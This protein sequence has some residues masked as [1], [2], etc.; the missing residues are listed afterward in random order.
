[1]KTNFLSKAYGGVMEARH[2]LYGLGLPRQWK[3]MTSTLLLLFTFAIGNVWAADPVENVGTYSTQVISADGTTS[4]WTFITPGSQVTIPTSP[5]E[6]EDNDIIFHPGGGSKMKFSSRN[7]LSW[8]GNSDGYIY[9]PAGAAGSISMTVK[10]ASDSRWLQ[11]Y[12][13]GVDQGS[14]KRLWSKEANPATAARGPRTFTFTSS[15]LTTKGEKTYLHL[16]D[17]NTEM[18]IATISITLTTGTYITPDCEDP[19]TALS[20]SSNAAATVYVG[21]E[22]TFSTSGGNGGTITIA[23]AASET[24]SD[25]KWTAT[26]GEH[27]FTASQAKN[28][29]YCGQADELVLTVNPKTPVT[30]VTI[31]G[32]TAGYLNDE[33]TFTA[34]AEYATSYRWTIDGVAQLSTTATMSFTPTTAKACSIICEAR[35]DFNDPGD[36]IA[37]TAHTY[38]ASK[39]C[40]ELIKIVQNGQSDGNV[41]GILTG[42]KDVKLSSGTSEYDEKTGRKIGSND[43]WLGVKELSKPL[44]AGDVATI[45]VTTV[46]AKL[47]L[48]ADKGTTLIGEME[49]GVVQGENEIVLNSSATGATAIYLYRT[50]T[51]GSDMNP[52]VHSLS[53]S[54]SCTESDD[55]S[56]SDVTINGESITPVGKVYSYEVA[57][58]SALTEVA[59][60]YAI[61]P[62]ATASPTSGFNVAVP[63]AGDPAN[64]QTITVTA[65][66]GTH[67]DTYTVSVTKAATASDVVTLDALAVTGYTLAPTFDAATLAYTITKAYGTAD[68]TADKVT[69]T[70]SEE[71]QTVDVVYDGTNHKFVVTVTA[72]DNTTTQDYEITINEAEAPK[73]LSRVL[74]SNGFDAFIDNTNHTVKAYYLAGATAPTATTITAGAGTA[75]E[76]S[77]GKIR[78][79]GADDSYVDYIVTLAEVTPNTTTVA[80]EAAAGE[81]AGDE[82]WVKNGLLVYGNAAGY[83]TGDKWYVN[84]RLKKGTDSEDDQRVIAGW[85]RSYFF[86]GNASKFIMTVGGNRNLDYTIDGGTP[87]ENV[88]VETLEIALTKGNHMIEIVS[89]QQSGDCRLSAPKLVELPASHTVTYMP[90]DGTGSWVVDDDAIEVAD[91]PNTFT[92]P[93]GKIFNGWKDG[94]NN[95]VEVGAAVTTD[96]ALTAQWINHYA[97]TFYMN[98][99]GDAIDPQ[100][101]KEGAK[102]TKPADPVVMGFDFGGWFTD[103]ACT[104]GNEF[105]F[106]TPITAATPLFAKWTEFEGCALLYPALS[107]DALHVGDNVAV[108]TGSAGGSIAVVGM[109]EEGSIAYD[110]NGLSLNGGGADV[111]SVTLNNDIAVGTKISVTLVA[112]NTGSRGLNLLNATGGKVKGGTKLGWDDATLGE[113]G[114]FSYTVEASDGLEGTNIFRLQRNNSVYLQCVKVESCGAAI[115]YHNLTSEVN[116]AGKGTVTLGASSVR[117]GYTT[118]A[119]YSEIDPLYEFVNWTVSGAGASIADASANPATITMGTE[120]AVVTLNLRLIPVKF[121]V[122]YYDGATL[123]GSEQVAVNENPTASEIVTAKRHYTFLGWSDT[124]GGDVVALNT[125]TRAEAGTVKLYAKYEAVVCPTS[126]TIFSMESDEAKKP[127]STVTI[128]KDA[129]IDLAEYA[130]ISGGNAMIINGET[131]GKDAIST[132]GE[133]LLKATKEVMKIELNCVLQEGDIIRILDNSA[134]LVISTSNA[135][136]GTYQAFADKNTHEFAVTAAWAGVDDIYVL[137]DGSSLKFTKVYVIRPA[138]YTVSFNLMGHGSAIADI[139]NVL[140]GSKITA[141]TAPT[142][143]D[144]SFAG[145]YKENTLA[146]EWKFDV[147]VVEANTTLYAKWLD[148]SDATLKSLK[149]GSTDIALEDGVF[150][151]NIALA[152]AT[153]AVPALTAVTNNPAATAV[154]TD[155]DAFDGDGKATSTVEVTP[156]KEGAAH[157]TYTVNFSKLAALPQV[158]VTGFTTWNFSAGGSTTL[159]NQSDVVLA[160]LPGINNDENF[161]SQALLGSFNKMEGTYFQGSKLSFTTEVPGKLTITFRGTNGNTRHL[162]ACVG[163]GETVVADW[164]Y[165][166]SSTSQTKTI[167]VP[168]GKVTLKAFEGETPNN[169]RIYNMTFNATPD[170]PRDV[171]E[172]RYGTICLPNSG[173]MTGADIFE[174]A[175]FEPS[176]SKIFFDQIVNGVMEAGMPYIFLPKAGATQLGV[177]YTD[178]ANAS[179]GHHN[180]LYGSYAQTELGTDGS[181]YIL[182]NNQYCQVINERVYVGANR[183]YIKLNEVSGTAVAPAPGRRRISMSVQGEQF[184]TGIE[185]AEANE[186]PRKVLING[187]LFILRGEKMY[188]AKGQLVK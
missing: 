67:S 36:W 56:I 71:A 91:C 110:A 174:I 44:R 50:S 147:D 72:E 21:D 22:I 150:E 84:R 166:S 188:D 51:T 169:A 136:T 74:F 32:E 40:G 97:V 14:T 131:S 57:A 55:C 65:E 111:I 30:E 133:F 115:T 45:F 98:G 128:A 43:Y 79:T 105:D 1:M 101:I 31:A 8:S 59:V 96:M 23:G 19:E 160:N 168:E 116:I 181:N 113:V 42:T 177:F 35:N 63:A 26:E 145:W 156:Q 112:A 121:T 143:E 119:T 88:N 180:G 76:L 163:D 12:V 78:V 9:V 178:E 153:V 140:E 148:K 182:L 134:K 53:V 17:N 124:D 102:A 80:E 4:T 183:A 34:T 54:R 48:F 146:N 64:T 86:V 173:V 151:Y 184:A 2:R 6:T 175:Y 87:V 27:T 144:Y 77:E 82:A 90:G 108:Q 28:G 85:V 66:D 149:Y 49:S 100:D 3:V 130:T 24:I 129:S 171:T 13:D 161:N 33:V 95:D 20:L 92:A 135:K 11:L 137:Y 127:A 162:Q 5:A 126:G 186:A 142:D 75:G 170:Y 109:K 70:K 164:V 7:G 103:A 38:T 176:S 154:V 155:D 81:F 89:H 125:I 167:F 157:L 39:L 185:S 152:A 165:N 62:L 94:D 73:S 158:N 25:G 132:D 58:A 123:M 172:G 69:Y 15:D 104:A 93:T 68:P 99:H 122:E 114:T 117:E 139:A 107:G 120:D 60:T 41:T 10:S 141:P 16:K 179:A 118:T 18:K 187:E 29:D 47:Q 61:H 37:S 159:T 83:S 46:S 52:F 106:E 138:K